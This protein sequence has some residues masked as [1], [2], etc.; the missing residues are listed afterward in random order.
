MTES[1]FVFFIS[2]RVLSHLL[3]VKLSLPLQSR[4]N[5]SFRQYHQRD[6][7][8]DQDNRSSPHCRDVRCSAVYKTDRHVIIAL[9]MGNKLRGPT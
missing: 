6:F 9:L 7:Y 5:S 8:R 1:S 3:A 4:V 2:P